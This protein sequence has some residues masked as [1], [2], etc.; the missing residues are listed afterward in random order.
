ML[1]EI[2]LGIMLGLNILG[3]AVLVRWLTRTIGALRGTVEA[4]E[5]TVSAQ[6][7]TLQA[8]N[9]LNR[10][11]IEVFRA[12]DPERWA[13]EVSIHKELADRK[14][15][16]IIDDERR[17]FERERTVSHQRFRETGEA[18]IQHYGEALGVAFKFLAYIPRSM[19]DQA[20]AEA[21]IRDSLRDKFQD[22]AK[23]APENQ[24]AV[25]LRLRDILPPPTSSV[26]GGV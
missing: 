3:G 10:T 4:L 9:Q 15:A 2:I 17:A 19:R 20:I 14:A 7:E 16:T 13:K 23:A 24:A 12:V 21:G 22:I 5:T 18:F 8:V 11:M 1:G 25:E 6:N 26:S